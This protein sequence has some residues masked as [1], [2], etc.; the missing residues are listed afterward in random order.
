MQT[1]AWSPLAMAL[2]VVEVGGGVE[3]A[4]VPTLTRA[5]SLGV[6]TGDEGVCRWGSCSSSSLIPTPPTP[7][8]HLLLRTDFRL[9]NCFGTIPVTVR[10]GDCR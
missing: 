2:A 1:H 4:H 6:S 5:L 3:L 10:Q 8:E 7:V 9:L